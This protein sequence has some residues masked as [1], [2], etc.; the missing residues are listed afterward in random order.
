MNINEQ[1]DYLLSG[2]IEVLPL[3]KEALADKLKKAENTKKPLRVK[4]GIDPTAADLHLGH[5]V[6]LQLLRRFLELGHKPVLIFGGFTAQ[7]GDPTG[8]NEA[9]L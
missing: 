6:C 5:T 3:G 2:G 7:L 1:I 9:S 4:L 8:R